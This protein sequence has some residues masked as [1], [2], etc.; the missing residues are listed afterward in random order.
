LAGSTPATI[1]I[2]IAVAATPG[3]TVSGPPPFGSNA[4]SPSPSPTLI[5]QGPITL[6][7][8]TQPQATKPPI[9][10]VAGDRTTTVGRDQPAIVEFELWLDETTGDVRY[11]EK[12]GRGQ[13]VIDEI[14]QGSKLTTINTTRRRLQEEIATDPNDSLLTRTARRLLAYQMA[15]TTEAAQRPTEATTR[16]PNGAPAI[17][18]QFPS[19]NPPDIYTQATVTPDEG[20]PLEEVEFD[21]KN[22]TTPIMRRVTQYQ[23]VERLTSRDRFSVALQ[24]AISTDWDVFTV[25]KLTPQAIKTYQ[26]RPIYWAG[27]TVDGKTIVLAEH[28][29]RRYHHGDLSKSPDDAVFEATTI[30]YDLISDDPALP[31]DPITIQT[32]YTVGADEI[33]T[34]SSTQGTIPTLP[35]RNTN[36]S[37]I[38]VSSTLHLRGINN[39][40][41][42][43]TARSIIS[44][45][46]ASRLVIANP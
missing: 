7:P 40:I 39:S 25:T 38:P 33:K 3:F 41:V 21:P 9:L 13:I 30:T 18:R 43:I 23:Q 37:I 16:A 26:N 20:L 28:T 2:T 27:P 10:H 1:A 44:P 4:P 35:V 24:P 45:E 5:V 29:I 14:R 46:L 15:R 31:S 19:S 42:L 11:T 36:E 22:P 12:N 8:P 17:R 34:I 6:Y 32:R